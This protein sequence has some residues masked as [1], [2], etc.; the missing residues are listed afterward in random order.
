MPKIWKFLTP[1]TLTAPP[2]YES[3]QANRKH[4][5]HNEHVDEWLKLAQCQEQYEA[6]SKQGYLRWRKNDEKYTPS[7]TPKKVHKDS[8]ALQHHINKPH[9]M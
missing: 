6:F 5:R 1:S 2:Q 9:G 7:P 4:D 8:C 3:Q